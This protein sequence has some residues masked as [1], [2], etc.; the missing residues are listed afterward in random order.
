MHYLVN[1]LWQTP[2]LLMAACL[3]SRILRKL[4]CAAQHRAW[5]AA[6]IVAAIAPLGAFERSG[7]SVRLLFVGR[8]VNALAGL[9]SVPAAGGLEPGT[10]HLV[11][12]L[13][14]TIL[15]AYLIFLVL[16][17]L[18][19]GW[20]LYKTRK[21]VRHKTA[22]VLTPEAAEI[23][24]RCKSAFAIPSTTLASSPD[25][26]GPV[27]IG[28]RNAVLL[29]PPCFLSEST[30]EDIAAALGHECAHLERRDFFLNLLY[31]LISLPIAYHPAAWMMKSRVAE[32]RE[33]V[34]DRMAAERIASSRSYASSLL[35]LAAAMRSTAASPHHAIGMFDAST[36]E[37]RIMSLMTSQPSVSRGRKMVLLA[38]GILLLSLSGV[39]AVALTANV[40]EL[41]NAGPQQ[42]AVERAQQP[43][44]TPIQSGSQNPPDSTP[45][46]PPTYHVGGPVSAPELFY[47]PDP[48]YPKGETKEGVVVIALIVDAKG[49][50][51]QVHVIRSFAPDFDKSAIGAVKQYR[52]MPAMLTAKSSRKPVAV[53]VNIEVNF[54]HH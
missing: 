36:L 23:W 21:L 14:F 18:R 48:K 19:L 43:I 41:A 49:I 33:L 3:V 10:I 39:A 52:F 13:Y 54:R 2:L 9:N 29:V 15:F 6:L 5:T 30:Q 11:P 47:A 42:A 4:G 35:R 16:G 28:T 24:Q 22:I 53:A 25:I 27:T 44:G 26:T 46:A 34:C 45:A 17:G 7:V 38:S 8:P 40:E 1:S 12:A 37:N 50:P 32:T 51:Q 31:Q 20:G